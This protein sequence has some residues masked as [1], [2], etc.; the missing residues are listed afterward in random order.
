[1]R[2]AFAGGG[3]GG[4]LVPGLHLLDDLAARGGVLEDLIWFTGGRPVEQRVLAGLAERVAPTPVRI[5]TLDLEAVGGGA[6]SRAR[7]GWRLLPAA[8]RARAL[9]KEHRSQVL[10]GLGGFV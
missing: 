7:Q 3:T 2:L 5:V 9:L 4:H 6:P 8:G 1:M 10:L